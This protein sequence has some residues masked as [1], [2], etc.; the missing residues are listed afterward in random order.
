VTSRAQ[1]ADL[2]FILDAVLANPDMLHRFLVFCLLFSL[3]PKPSISQ[4]YQEPGLLWKISGN[5]LSKPSYL[6]GTLHTIS[7]NRFF[8][9]TYTQEAFGSCKILATENANLMQYLSESDLRNIDS[10]QYL[11]HRK[12]LADVMEKSQYDSLVAVL[13][14]NRIYR[15]AYL[16]LKPLYLA[17]MLTSSTLKLNKHNTTGY[18]QVF[19]SWALA[20][21]RT[22]NHMGIVG[23][24]AYKNTLAYL[25]SL[26]MELQVAH[27]MKSIRTDF[28]DARHMYAVYRQENIQGLCEL[29][30]EE[31]EQYRILVK[32]RN[33]AWLDNIERLIQ[34]KPT[35]I[36]VGAAHLAGPDG[37]I[38]LLIEMGYTLMPVPE[39]NL[40]KR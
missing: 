33:Q 32:A 2:C 21:N 31:P 38:Q 29:A 12:T 9:P 28:R 37:L 26:N 15:K 13:K 8:M 30:M 35:F 18:E 5:G 20:R 1:L 19:Y 14:K 23:L 17:G 24:E 11:P 6:Y 36:A 25:D 10:R 22:G 3:F 34:S 40:S 7:K 16:R 27:L 4:I 39:M